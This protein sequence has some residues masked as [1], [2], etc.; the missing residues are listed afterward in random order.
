MRPDLT[1]VPPARRAAAR[2]LATRH[3]PDL[4]YRLARATY[5]T[6]AVADRVVE[7]FESLPG[8]A[9][10]E[11]LDRTLSEGL[12]AVPDAPAALSEMLEPILE[13]PAWVDYDR[14]NAGAAAFWRAGTLH[15]FSI[16]QVLLAGYESAAVVKPLVRSGRLEHMAARRVEET[17]QWFIN[18]TAPGAM[19]PGAAGIRATVRIRLVH[20]LIRR[21][22][23][24]EPDWE[25]EAWGEPI[26][27]AHN[28]GTLAGAFML[29]PVRVLEDAGVRFSASEHYAICHLFSWVG[30]VMGV[31][32]DLL[33]PSF[34]WT[35]EM[36]AISQAADPGP[37]ED[38]RRL[39]AALLGNGMQPER[40][41]PAPLRPLARPP[42]LWI[43]R[44]M[45][46][47]LAL[48]SPY[49]LHPDELGL[50]RTPF[51]H[52]FPLLRPLVWAGELPRAFGLLGP[53]ERIARRQIATIAWLI[54]R[55]GGSVTEL[56]P[57]DVESRAA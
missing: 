7:A 14:V 11:L 4:V 55:L 43:S 57:E 52:A 34:E 54:R 46:V 3:D 18:A 8:G 56:Q 20:A 36:L 47:G 16:L 24:G 12:A 21:R 9:G 29:V 48:R 37:D 15:S 31:P 45:S 2:E 33:P 38:S 49:L 39:T 40:A 32:D 51:K 41:L 5:E 50:P 23:A 25:R 17:G 44:H 13:P 22:L 42:L 27:Q 53:D 35:E 10:W 30:H 26:N 6:D 28:A 1:G 19:L